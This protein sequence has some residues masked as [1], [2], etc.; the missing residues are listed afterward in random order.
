[1]ST[2]FPTNLDSFTN[3]TAT[4]PLNNPSHSSEHA[5]TNDSIAALETKVGVDSSAVTSTI[6]YKLKNS[7]SIDPG[8]H[9]TNVSL[10]SIASSKVSGLP[11]FPSGAIVGTT[12]SQVLTNKTISGSSNTIG[13]ILGTSTYTASTGSANA[14]IMT[15]S[16]AVSAYAAG[17]IYNFLAN[18]GNT[19][20]ATLNVNSLGANNIYKVNGATALAS[21]D[22]ASGQLVTVAYDGTQ[23]QMLSPV[24]NTEIFSVSDVT[25]SRSLNSGYTNSTGRNLFI[26]VSVATS[27]G[28]YGNNSTDTVTAIVGG[29]SVAQSYGNG[30][31]TNGSSYNYT[32]ALSFVVPNGATY[33]VNSSGGN[34]RS[35]SIW[36]ETKI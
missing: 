24:G 3:P 26:N 33:Q 1:M 10:D 18:F 12:D 17:Q 13:N 35:L 22:I 28:T 6:D 11:T 9:H 23:F 20:A 21:G 32:Y 31:Y 7:A 25:G 36:I 15:P 14:Y 16:P 30:Y 34:N 2:V 8:H 29:V 4:N 5:N 19:G 27:G